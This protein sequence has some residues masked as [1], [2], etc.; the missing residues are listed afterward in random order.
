MIPNGIISVGT[1][2][3]YG[4]APEKISGALSVA[5][6]VLFRRVS[7]WKGATSTEDSPVKRA[8]KFLHALEG[9]NWSNHMDI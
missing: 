4:V 8:S 6:T 5:D 1:K 3:N 7:E 2:G 9:T